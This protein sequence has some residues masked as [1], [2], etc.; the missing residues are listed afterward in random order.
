MLP[1]VSS[2]MFTVCAEG[3]TYRNNVYENGIVTNQSTFICV[4]DKKIVDYKLEFGHGDANYLDDDYLYLPAENMSLFNLIR[5]YTY[6]SYFNPNEDGLNATINCTFPDYLVRVR[7]DN[8]GTEVYQ[9]DDAVTAKFYW[10]NL[11]G[12]WFRLA[13][14]EQ[15]VHG[16]E[17]GDTYN[18]SCSDL[19]YYYSTGV[20]RA[21]F[22]NKSIEVRSTTPL[23]VSSIATSYGSIQYTITN[24]EKYPIYDVEFNW[25]ANNQ[26][27][28]ENIRTLDPNETIVYDVFV[29]GT[30]NLSLDASYVP[31]WYV[32]SLK[33][34]RYAQLYTDAVNISSGSLAIDRLLADNVITDTEIV[35]TH[36][37]ELLADR[38]YKARLVIE[39]NAQLVNADA[40]PTI[41]IFDPNDFDETFNMTQLS[42]GIYGFNLTIAST[43]TAGVWLT[44]VDLELG[45]ESL[46]R[47]DFWELEANPAQVLVEVNDECLLE[48]GAELTIQ[49]EGTSSQEY[50]YRCWITPEINGAYDDASAIDTMSGAKL[51]TPYETWTRNI[52]LTAET[53][54]N[55]YY[56]CQAFWGTENSEASDAFTARHCGGGSSGNLLT[57]FVTGETLSPIIEPR[58]QPWVFAFILFGFVFL[59]AWRRRMKVNERKTIQDDTVLSR[60][61]IN[62]ELYGEDV[63]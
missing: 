59:F 15:E 24:S 33:P 14:L 8:Y 4:D 44:H 36:H 48:V 31:V 22:E 50:Q 27:F 7:Q 53:P 18:V 6:G 47:F 12:N 61:P 10:D 49:N 34:K 56:K 16:L 28:V 62:K 40:L 26:A 55:L 32:T 1:I 19:T 20:V 21:S 57:G 38:M 52:E 41:T 63:K 17:V 46:S 30:G 5:V 29:T 43:E 3:D 54:A 60:P 42:T 37:P 25:Q 58:Y 51:I 11:K 13:P 45:G 35:L 9:G 23:N 2:S 39:Q